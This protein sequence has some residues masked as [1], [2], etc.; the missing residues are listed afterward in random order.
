M[1]G[2]FLSK[3]LS[4]VKKPLFKKKNEQTV[5]LRHHPKKRT[6]QEDVKEVE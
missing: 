2:V 1:S 3:L 4:H 6:R 5:S